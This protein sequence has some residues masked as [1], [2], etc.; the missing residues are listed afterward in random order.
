MACIK[1]RGWGASLRV[2]A[3]AAKSLRDETRRGRRGRP[4]NHAHGRGPDVELVEAMRA[5]V[6]RLNTGFG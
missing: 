3:A 1:N 6:A 5:K 2:E 4:A